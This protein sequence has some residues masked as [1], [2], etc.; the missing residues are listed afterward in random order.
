MRFPEKLVH[1][2]HHHAPQTTHLAR[3]ISILWLFIVTMNKVTHSRLCYTIL[4]LALYAEAYSIEARKL[5]FAVLGRRTIW[6]GGSWVQKEKK[7]LQIHQ[8]AHDGKT[9]MMTNTP[10]PCSSFEVALWAAWP[11]P[12]GIGPPFW[13]E[14]S[15]VY[16][17]LALFRLKQFS[18]HQLLW[19]CRTYFTPSRIHLEEEVLFILPV[20][21]LGFVSLFVSWVWF[22]IKKVCWHQL[23]WCYRTYFTS[24]WSILLTHGPG[25]KKHASCSGESDM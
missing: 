12:M 4:L 18:V 23:L 14:L 10:L 8:Q 20:L 3:S 16:H 25:R 17:S 7:K 2:P 9:T 21:P 15:W 6:K 19:C 11:K 5:P 22:R 13:S 1:A 24:S